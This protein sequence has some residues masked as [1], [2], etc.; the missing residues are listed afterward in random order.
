M[1]FYQDKLF[2]LDMHDPA[3]PFAPGTN[4]N[5]PPGC[6]IGIPATMRV[7]NP[8]TGKIIWE[9][10]YFRVSTGFISFKNNVVVLEGSTLSRNPRYYSYL[11]VDVQSGRVLR[12][13]CYEDDAI[14]QYDDIDKLTSTYRP[15]FYEGQWMDVAEEPPFVT[16]GSKLMMVNRQSRIPVAEIEF[17]GRPLD[18]AY[19][20]ILVRNDFLIVYLD[21]S[22]Q[23]FTFRMK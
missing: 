21:D 4:T 8:H 1:H 9:Y 11:D 19:V 6:N 16:D 13:A 10:S 18:S 2:S 12:G 7:Y 20:Q 22:N 5:I 15:I 23:F 17:S 14:S 3:V